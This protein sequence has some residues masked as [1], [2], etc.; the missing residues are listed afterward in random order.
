MSCA[1]VESRDL[2]NLPD[3]V[4]DKLF[5]YLSLDDRKSIRLSCRPLYAICNN[6]RVQKYEEIVF[7]GNI[8]TVAAIRSLSVSKRKMWNMRLYRVY[9]E[10][11]CILEF[12]QYQ[13]IKVHS[14]TF[15]FC[16]LAPGIFENIIKYC[17]NLHK[18]VIIFDP[19]KGRE[20]CKHLLDDFKALKNHDIV[21][22]SV[23]SFILK[24]PEGSMKLDNFYLTKGDFLCFF[25][26]F[27]NIKNLNLTIEID[28]NFDNSHAK[29]IDPVV[30]FN[31]RISFSCIY[32]QVMK[33]SQQL[34]KLHLHFTYEC[35]LSGQWLSIRALHR[36][37][38]IKMEKLKKFSLNWIE[39][40][41]ETII[42][43]FS[44]L[45]HLTDFDCTISSSVS[46][47]A[48]VQLLLSN[49]TELQSLTVRTDNG[50]DM[51]SECFQALVNSRLVILNFRVNKYH[52]NHAHDIDIYTK[53]IIYSSHSEESL[54]R[55]SLSPN[56]TLKQLNMSTDDRLLLL[57]FGNY[58]QNLENLIFQDI[59]DNVLFRI[60]KVQK[61]V[62]SLVLYNCN[63][64]PLANCSNEGSF[65]LNW[66]FSRD[67]QL[68]YHHF[69]DLTHLH[70]VEEISLDL[71]L[72][73][74]SNFVFPKLKSLKIEIPCN[75]TRPTS[76]A[77]FLALWTNIEKFTQ[78]VSLDIRCRSNTSFQQWLTL[79]SALPKLRYFVIS[80]HQSESFS[81]AQ[82]EYCFRIHPSLS[83]IC[84][85]RP[86]EHIRIGQSVF[87]GD[88]FYFRNI[89]TNSIEKKSISHAKFCSVVYQKS[90][91]ICL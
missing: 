84:V 90:P 50:F 89:I 86:K 80:A 77:N 29:V 18:I 35:N 44:N 83:S 27:A 8:N 10:D 31:S 45:K 61:K 48:F 25:D 68:S 5:T 59:R 76:N 40:W 66:W 88:V 64:Y 72:F 12:F 3:K 43:P 85:L 87:R 47:S 46:Q 13:G 60:L 22:T 82:Y 42:D 16:K 67:S 65:T 69:C 9:V 41:D 75:L 56:H 52:Y 91:I 70:I 2:L 15:E 11:T 57:L 78:L 23:K 28:K 6:I 39:L 58:F 21:R 17:Q 63:K 53:S 51:N 33:M 54:W 81:D 24:I 55:N 19:S 30:N 36:I 14:L 4:W 1:R 37:A 7:H 32:S 38:D 62:R 73:M 34:E 71:S 26:V 74:F 49:A 20:H 79:L